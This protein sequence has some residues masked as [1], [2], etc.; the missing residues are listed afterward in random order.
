MA[1]CISCGKKKRLCWP[2]KRISGPVAC[3]QKCMAERA[4][5]VYLAA[6]DSY[7]CINCGDW[8]DACEGSC[9]G[10]T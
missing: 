8:G 1:Y 5:D 7:H 10:E 3:S 9:E 4:Y 2:K 6:P